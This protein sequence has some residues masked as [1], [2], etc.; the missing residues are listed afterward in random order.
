M[1]QKFIGLDEAAEK[2]GVS[3]DKLNQLR[4]D[5][6][7]RAYRDGA[8]WKFRAEEIDRLES[9]GLPSSEPSDLSLNLFH[10]E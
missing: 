2:L 7:L 5:G 6:Q 10:T 8:S 3:T 9:E 1:A 4:E